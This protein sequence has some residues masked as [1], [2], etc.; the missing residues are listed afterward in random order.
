MQ[1]STGVHLSHGSCHSYVLPVHDDVR[2]DHVD[3]GHMAVAPLLGL[4]DGKKGVGSCDGEVMV[5]LRDS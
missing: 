2:V 1:P 4:T 5:A 3:I